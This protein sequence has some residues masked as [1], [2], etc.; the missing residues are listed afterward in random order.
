MK[1]NYT[2][3]AFYVLC[4]VIVLLVYPV[5]NYSA[6]VNRTAPVKSVEKVQKQV[7]EQSTE[8]VHSDLLFKY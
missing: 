5:K 2:L 7:A 4:V 6:I 8:T 1:R 3:N